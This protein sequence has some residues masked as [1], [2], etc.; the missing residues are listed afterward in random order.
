MYPKKELAQLVIA[1]CHQFEI[2]TVV[3][4]PGS[5]NA[6]LTVG[7]SNHKDF[8]TISLVD[9]RCAAFFALGIAQ[10]TKR[11]VAVLCTSGSALLNYYPAIAEAFYSNIP[12][13]VISADRPKHLIDIGDGQ[14]I[15]QENVFENHILFSANLIENP[16]FKARNSQLIGEALQIAT[17][18]QGPVHINVPFDEPL[19]ETVKTLDTFHFPHISM[20]SVD[21]SHVNYSFFGDVWNAA[22]KKIILV[23]VNYPDEKI[24]ELIH[25]YAEDPSVLI[26]TETT[27]NLHHENVVDAID[28]LI[29][30]LSDAEFNAL[31][32]EVLI[33]FGG[34][35][36][37]KRVKQFLRKYPPKHHWDI[38][39]KKATNTF[40]CLTEF[41]Q[42][43][44][45]AFF[46]TFNK[47]V[48][49]VATDYQ[50]KWLRLR[51]E[52][53]VKHHRYLSKIE[54][55]DFKVFEQVLE[56]IPAHSNLQVSNSAIIRYAQLF[57]IK[58]SIN[59]FCNRGTS[60]I[61]GS[62]STAI[63]AAFSSE[64]QTVF[65]TGDLSFFY[66]S[67]ALW[68]AHIP[69]SFRI[70]IINNSGGGIFK[71]IPGPSTTNATAY[72]ETP[73]CLTAENLC[74]M[75][76]FE[77][78]VAATTENVDKELL[79]FYAPSEKPKILEIFTPSAK[80]NIVLTA[81]FKYIK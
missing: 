53:R 27:S 7:F 57:S 47:Q 81:Y 58:K 76:G 50:Q 36:I 2:D 80:N 63:G 4:S 78:H 51:D 69:A 21:N 55:S 54:H 37:S 16:R 1:A 39:S 79:G 12:L 23:G 60:G 56:S 17:S 77:Y 49:K 22:K 64:K 8:K 65:V 5:R 43:D 75:H 25:F 11:P 44:P 9:E 74:K 45:I 61:D 52:K 38:D 31:Q 26:L 62:T 6:P 3:I 13:V 71:I 20:S 29:F 66:D 68:N 32:P 59:V 73:H 18:N 24:N 41:I 46:E 70:I 30:S 28:Q 42:Q 15:R 33:T 72:F 10:Q 19:Y 48:F 67:N 40:F 14:T 35:V 34:M